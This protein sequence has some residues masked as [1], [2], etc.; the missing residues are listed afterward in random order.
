MSN[1]LLPMALDY[2]I[3]SRDIDVQ[4]L[5]DTEL[6]KLNGRPARR[7]KAV[8]NIA[9]ADQTMQTAFNRALNAS[10]ASSSFDY[11]IDGVKHAIG[12]LNDKRK[13]R[14]LL[15]LEYIKDQGFTKGSGLGSLNHEM[16]KAGAGFM[17]AAF[18]LRKLLRSEGK[19]SDYVD[20]M[21]WYT[22]FGEVYQDNFE[23]KGTT[24]DRMRTISLWRL[25]AVLMMPSLTTP[26]KRQKVRDMNALVRWYN[27]A[28]TPN[29]AFAGLLKPDFVAFHHFTFYAS[30]YTPQALHVA[31]LIQ[32]LLSGTSFC[33]EIK[34]MN[35]IEKGL[36][37]LR[38]VSVKY[39]TPNSVSGRFPGFTRAILS[40]ILPAYAYA[41]ANAPSLDGNGKLGAISVQNNDI[42][43]MFVRLYEK[44]TVSLTIT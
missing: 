15:L 3:R 23:Y 20:T 27:N 8:Q 25:F 43:R 21:K 12:Q 35:N 18:V 40:K 39:S 32:Y 17:T 36:E 37:T 24:A 9:G 42:I 28:M 14:L 13:E 29:E 19:L 2:H 38:I 33:L 5:A 7:D 6:S 10:L 34:S 4:Q 41:A 22:D 31:A 11:T 26:E 16:N 44:V 1:V 30:S